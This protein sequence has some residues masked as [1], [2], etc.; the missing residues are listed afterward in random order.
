M[1]TP[2]RL[3]LLEDSPDDALL[4]QNLLQ[5]EYNDQIIIDHASTAQ[6]ATQLA[7][8]E[9]HHLFLIDYMLGEP[10]N[11]AEWLI[12]IRQAIA[13][14][15]VI[16]LTGLP[17]AQQVENIAKKFSSISYF[18]TKDK[19]QSGALTQAIHFTLINRPTSHS[20]KGTILLVDDDHDNVILIEDALQDLD[21]H[22]QLDAVENGDELI[23]YLNRHGQ[24]E[25]L[26]NTPLPGLIMLDLNMPRMNGRELLKTVRN[27]EHLR[28]IPIV[29]FSTA[30]SEQD[31]YDCYH[32]GANSFIVK[33]TSFNGLVTTMRNLTNYWFDLVALPQTS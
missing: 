19:I 5:K 2:L 30:A 32:L 31:I 4:V 6:E 10:P 20:S 3:L 7:L 18:I 17:D 12:Q 21:Q 29:I 15:P 9:Q 26:Q 8:S 27:N 16:M 24:Y 22:Y 11:G 14:P 1:N 33:P 13:I 28:R 25:H 23:D